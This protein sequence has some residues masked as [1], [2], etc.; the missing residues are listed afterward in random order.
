MEQILGVGREL[1]RS[2]G[3]GHVLVHC[4]AG[5]SRSTA[6]TAILLAQDNPGRE[7]EAFAAVARLR[8][9]A[10]PNARMVDFA[11]DLLERDGRLRAGLRAMQD[12]RLGRRTGSRWRFF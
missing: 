2:A 4:H 12:S 9:G 3:G 7:A 5:V 8:P 11:D 1:A 6:A 10:W